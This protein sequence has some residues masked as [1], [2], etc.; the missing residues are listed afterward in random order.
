M[1]AALRRTRGDTQLIVWFALISATFATAGLG[2]EQTAGG[3]A[4]V[5]VLLLAIAFTKI[6]LVGIHFM[7]LGSAPLPLRLLFEGYVLVTF[8]VLVVLFLVV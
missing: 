8:T 7:E 2:L 3:A 6:R 1:L 5:G 4:T